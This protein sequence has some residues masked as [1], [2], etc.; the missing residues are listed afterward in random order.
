MKG[1]P[2]VIGIRGTQHMEIESLRNR[3]ERMMAGAGFMWWEISRRYGRSDAI[4]PY[5]Q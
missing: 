2:E 4:G 5:G 1:L 3:M